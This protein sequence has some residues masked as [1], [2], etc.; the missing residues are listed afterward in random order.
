VSKLPPALFA[1][2][3]DELPMGLAVAEAPSGQ[4][5]FANQAFRRLLGTDPLQGI[6]IGE[7]P[8]AYGIFDRQGRPYPAEQLPF[9][10]VLATRGPVTVDDLVVHRND[11]RHIHL[12]AF[13]SPLGDPDSPGHVMLAFTDIRDEV[14]EAGARKSAE[15]RLAFAVDHA[16]IVLWMHDTKGTITL[17]EG[18]ALAGLGVRPG[19]LVGQSAFDLYRDQPQ[20]VENIRRALEG[21][22]ISDLY[23]R[24]P[25]TLQS[26]L[27]PVRGA[28]GQVEGVIG[29]AT[30]VSEARR[31][32][33]QLM[34]AERMDAIGR[35]SGGIA[36]DFNNLIGAIQGFAWVCQQRLPAA[37]PARDDLEQILRACQ[38]AAGL[39]K[40]LLDFGRT[41]PSRVEVVDA[42]ELVRDLEKV[43]RLVV[44]EGV[45]LQTQVAPQLGRVQAG[46]AHLERVLMNLVVN[47]REAMPTG[48]TLT[49]AVDSV[50]VS[51]PAGGQPSQVPPGSYV[52]F[53]VMDTGLGMDEATRRR[54]FEPFFTTKEAGQGTGLGL[55]SVY[56]I[57]RQNRGHITV[58]TEVGRGTTVVVYLPCTDASPTAGS[59]LPAATS[60][61]GN[62]TVLLVEDEEM[63][64][65]LMAEVLRR[66]G[67]L[68]LEAPNAGEALLVCEQHP[69][70]IQLLL[71]DVIMPRI[72]GVALATRVKA[73]RPSVRVAF[74]SGYTG[75]VLAQQGAA[76]S[77]HVV[78]EK[79]FSP[80][81][82]LSS[83]RAVLTS[84]S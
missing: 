51:P 76:T 33:K 77:D 67:Y 10:R 58:A 2:V 21:E 75:E 48:G 18:A 81:A 16:P 82:L 23:E 1:A 39:V 30:D 61:G 84:D 59:S 38:R 70:D 8:A 43:F 26:H 56:G 63:V 13:A 54:M 50:T 45:V 57:V 69:G 7:V 73:L 34:L 72:N 71:T 55:A 27:E 25:L 28:D 12:R 9:S 14:R 60:A 68:V 42:G 37:E 64:R 35:L 40:Q 3:L 36:H 29:V 78:I 49:I 17:S 15:S 5:V 22:P 44:G 4:V 32:E 66:A 62:E 52:R 83:V 41:Q 20:V 53:A 11:G 74:V 46:A 47:A 80:Q 6:G 19:Q 24:G 79:P 31:L 65:R